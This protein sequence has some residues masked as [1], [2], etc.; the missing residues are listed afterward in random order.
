MDSLSRNKLNLY[1]ED[2]NKYLIH[3]C[4]EDRFIE[5]VIESY[6]HNDD[7]VDTRE[8][9]GEI[10]KDN[11]FPDYRINNLQINYEFGMSLLRKY[12]SET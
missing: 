12:N 9:L 4:D 7:M 8:E 10:L 5:F 1:M 3:F 2:A 11:K 6:K